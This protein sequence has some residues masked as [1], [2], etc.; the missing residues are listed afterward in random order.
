VVRS[1]LATRYKVI[2]VARPYFA[3]VTVWVGQTRYLLANAVSFA[4]PTVPL[5]PLLNIKSGAVILRSWSTL[6]Q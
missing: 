1:N 2:V 6:A 4:P 5:G 3:R